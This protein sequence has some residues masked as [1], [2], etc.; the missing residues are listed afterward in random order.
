MSAVFDLM[1]D[2]ET[3]ERRLTKA[4]IVL[5]TNPET[6]FFA[7]T[8]LLGESKIVDDHPTACTNG[9]DKYYGRKFMST[10]TQPQMIGVVLHENLHVLL[11]HIMRHEDLFEEDA[12]LANAAMDYVVNA[13]ITKVKGYGDWIDLPKDP[14]PLFDPKFHDWAVRDVY[15]F[16]KKGRN[17]PKP[18]PPPS[19]PTDGKSQDN[20][21][22]TE[23][24]QGTPDE[25]V[26]DEGNEGNQPGS[27]EVDGDEYDVTSMDEHDV[28]HAAD[29][30]K[31][32]IED[33][34]KEI[35]EAIHQA[36]TLAGA[37]GMDLPRAIQQAVEPETD[38]RE[39]LMEFFTSSMRG[40]EESSW[41]RYDMRRLSIGDYLPSKHNETLTELVLAIDASG[42]MH[43]K[44]FDIACAAV[45]NACITLKPDKVRVLFWDTTVCA[46]QIFEGDYES[47]KDMLKPRGGGGT[48]AAC[49][50]E[51]L[52]SN[53]I[54]PECVVVITDGY[55]EHNITWHTYIPTVW[56][57]LENESFMPPKGRRVK[58]KS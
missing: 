1:E 17:N 12:Q 7:S 28:D 20:G 42:S 6:R 33:L 27:V 40:N 22:P 18:P 51:Y 50:P 55:L 39:E 34:T 48:R 29:M 23:P 5:I 38:W 47:M 14:K 3:L 45:V 9:R 13:I 24:S 32:Q 49:V 35:D 53:N 25:Q 4:H 36:T 8:V 44:L 58:V 54:K 30:T 52:V 16:L 41:R 10:L 57:V 31:E 43:G 15:N 26:S 21:L 11:K 37:L 46:E 2:T 56:L 19:N